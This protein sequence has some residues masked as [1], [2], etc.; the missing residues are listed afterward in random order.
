MPE[1]VRAGQRYMPGLDGLR[2]IAVLA[3]IAFHE[4]LGWAPE[5]PALEQ[6]VADAWAFTQQ[7]PDGY[8][9]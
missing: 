1:P 2:A 8:S 6:M 4:Q 7:H 9:D 5:K 3:V